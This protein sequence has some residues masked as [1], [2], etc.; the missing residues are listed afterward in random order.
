MLSK[1]RET[2]NWALEVNTMV[3]R[4]LQP[5]S[6]AFWRQRERRRLFAF[7]SKD[8]GSWFLKWQLPGGWRFPAHGAKKTGILSGAVYQVC[9]YFLTLQF[10]SSLP[11]KSQRQLRLTKYINDSVMSEAACFFLFF[12]FSF[13]FFCSEYNLKKK[14]IS[15]LIAAFLLVH[16]SLAFDLVTCRD[17]TE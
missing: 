3:K 1:I 7:A 4:A 9:C 5:I 17:Q 14:I 15:I 6:A 16:F 10:A 12:F 2:A 13:L 11:R 8:D